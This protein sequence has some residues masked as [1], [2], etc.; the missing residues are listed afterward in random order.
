M[1]KTCD[2]YSTRTLTRTEHVSI[3][4]KTTIILDLLY[5]TVRYHTVVVVVVYD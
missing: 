4:P 2:V 5:S 3:N 1:S